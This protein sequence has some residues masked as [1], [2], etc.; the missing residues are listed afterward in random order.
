MKDIFIKPKTKIDNLVIAISTRYGGVSNTPYQSMNTALHVGDDDANVFENRKIL[1]DSLGLDIN[2]SVFADQVH[3]T[4][5]Y[6]VETSDI[7]SG[8]LSASTAIQTDSF[9]T[10]IKN[11]PI[12]IQTADCLSIVLYAKDKHAI[13]NIHCGWKG[14]AHGIIQNTIEAMVDNYSVAPNDIYVYFGACIRSNNF[15]VSE[16]VASV[17]TKPIVKNCEFYVDL[18]LEARLILEKYGI[19]DIE[20]SLLDSHEERFY[21]YRRDNKTTGRMSTIAMLC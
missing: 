15:N 5:V 17:F 9:I 14:I 13:A 11:I 1:F 6:K 10:N 3:S 8:A 16:D 12:I 4:D 20:D 18:T 21:S 2:K 7:G 19:T